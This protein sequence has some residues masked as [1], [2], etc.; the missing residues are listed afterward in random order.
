MC[1]AE[2]ESRGY[3]CTE[4]LR[5]LTTYAFKH[6]VARA[7]RAAP[8]LTVFRRAWLWGVSDEDRAEIAKKWR[9]YVED[10]MIYDEPGRP[11]R[12]AA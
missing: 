12:F 2:D 3:G 4:G 1:Y 10:D 9:V 5:N 11:V 8:V 6:T 7:P